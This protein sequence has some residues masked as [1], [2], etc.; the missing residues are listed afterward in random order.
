MKKELKSTNQKLPKLKEVFFKMPCYVQPTV[1]NLKSLNLRRHKS[2]KSSK[3]ESVN[4]WSLCLKIDSI[5]ESIINIVPDLFSAHR[6]IASP[7]CATSLNLKY[8][9]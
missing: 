8:T 1:Q 2:E 5:N 9:T 3:S 7:P 4:P 6:L